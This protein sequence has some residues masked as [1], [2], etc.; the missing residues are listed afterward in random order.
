MRDLDWK[1]TC[2]LHP[3]VDFPCDTSG[4]L[5]GRPFGVAELSECAVACARRRK[6]R[7]FVHLTGNA[8]SLVRVDGEA[9]AGACYLKRR[10]AYEPRASAAGFTS[11]LC[12]PRNASPHRASHAVC[13]QQVP[14]PFFVILTT[15]RNHRTRCRAILDTWG[16][17]LATEDLAFYSDAPDPVLPVVVVSN[18]TSYEGAQDRFTYRV[19]PDA[20][21]R[22]ERERHNWLVVLDDDTFVW[23]EN[24]RRVLASRNPCESVW[25]GQACSPQDDAEGPTRS[26]PYRDFPAFCG[27]AG[28][29]MSLPVAR[30]ASHVAPQC[31]EFA[32]SEVPYDRRMGVCL[33][34]LLDLAV[35]DTPEFHSQPPLFYAGSDPP[36]PPAAGRRERRRDFGRAATFHHLRGSANMS[37]PNI[38]VSAEALYRA[39]WWRTR[40]HEQQVVERRALAMAP[41]HRGHRKPHTEL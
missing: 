27:G 31:A 1:E 20:V 19:I 36:T 33:Q 30:E 41:A 5:L 2:R 15:Y 38:Y 23:P 21:A 39:L 8:K 32:A 28:F 7:A 25:L 40:E 12:N 37:D 29:A 34:G 16:G 9:D 6:C 22:M 24:L 35:E 26:E 13:D 4:C 14:R 11:G 18:D 17:G 3:R 10:H